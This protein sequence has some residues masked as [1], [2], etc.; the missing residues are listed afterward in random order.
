MSLAVIIGNDRDD[1]EF[2]EDTIKILSL[3]KQSYDT[4][5]ENERLD[6]IIT[7]YTGIHALLTDLTVFSS[8]EDNQPQV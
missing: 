2:I 4:P 3:T 6:N 5:V 1:I 7:W 8:S